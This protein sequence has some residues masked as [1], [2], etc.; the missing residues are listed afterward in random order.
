MSALAIIK[1][2]AYNR[3]PLPSPHLFHWRDCSHPVRRPCVNLSRMLPG[4]R[5]TA[6]NSGTGFRPL[7]R[8]D[9]YCSIRLRTPQGF[10]SAADFDL[11]LRI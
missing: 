7:S 4:R 11:G 2:K 8:R 1:Q 3:A 9:T 10:P 6:R 5:P